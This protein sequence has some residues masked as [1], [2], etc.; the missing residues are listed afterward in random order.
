MK[1]ISR[2]EI[3]AFDRLYKINLINSCSGYKSANLIGTLSEDGVENL[4]VFSSVIHLGSSPPLLGFIMRPT[5]V[6]RHTFDNLRRSGFYSINHI[7]GDFAAL[8]HQTS[9]KYPREI[10]EFEETGLT[11]CYRHDFLAP[12]VQESPVQIAMK[13]ADQIPIHANDTILVIGEIQDIYLKPEMLQEDGF[14]DLTKGDVVAIN[15]LDAYALPHTIDRFDYARPGKPVTSLV[16]NE[17]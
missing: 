13:Y 12:F 16:H 9:A 4:A 3:A 11:P 10:S 14:L 15:G 1:R 8:A 2:S 17:G 6:P 5:T 7:S